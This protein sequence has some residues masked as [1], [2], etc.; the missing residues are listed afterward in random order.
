MLISN[1]I[2]E[3]VSQKPN[4]AKTSET[5]LRLM[6]QGL[7]VY[8]FHSYH[9]LSPFDWRFDRRYRNK[10]DWCNWFS[11]AQHS[12]PV[13]LRFMQQGLRCRYEEFECKN[14][15][16]QIYKVHHQIEQNKTFSMIPHLLLNKEYFWSYDEKHHIFSY[17][18][19]CISTALIPIISN[20]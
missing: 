2:V 3:M 6:Q 9:A 7:F 4:I 18:F 12:Y 14:R 10:F 1:T 13:P 15:Y 17:Y 11:F 16:I 8:H 20:W 5:I 19:L